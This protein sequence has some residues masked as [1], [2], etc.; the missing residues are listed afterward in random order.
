[1]T[2]KH[3]QASEREGT[4]C[5][6]GKREEEPI[7][8]HHYTV[9]CFL[10]KPLSSSPVVLHVVSSISVET[11]HLSSFL[12]ENAFPSNVTSSYLFWANYKRW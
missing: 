10:K 11:P 3:N 7:E 5:K 4:Y 8:T 2:T 6:I 12:L 1:M 9:I